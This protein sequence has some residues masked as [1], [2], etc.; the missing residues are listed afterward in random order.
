VAGDEDIPGIVAD[1]E[2]NQREIGRSLRREIFC[3][4]NRGV[5]LTASQRLLQRRGEDAPPADHGQRRGLIGIALGPDDDDVKRD[6]RVPGRERLHHQIRLAQGQSA[7][8]GP[9]P[10]P[11]THLGSDSCRWYRW[12]V[13]RRNLQQNLQICAKF[14]P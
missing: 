7:T 8:A 6:P 10:N 3:R 4:V 2:G 5:D 11:L 1:E 9:E 14:C 12:L 13:G